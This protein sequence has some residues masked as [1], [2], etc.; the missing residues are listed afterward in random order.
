M[1]VPGTIQ[2]TC[3][4][5]IGP[6]GAEHLAGSRGGQDREPQRQRCHAVLPGECRQEFADLAPGQSG[7][8]LHRANLGLLREHVLHEGPDE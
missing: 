1:R 5:S 7:V 4:G 6:V 8:V 2:T 3:I